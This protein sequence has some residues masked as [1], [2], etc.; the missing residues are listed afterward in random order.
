[1]FWKTINTLSEKQ[2]EN[3]N[4]PCKSIIEHFKRIY[5]SNPISDTI[6]NDINL[7]NDRLENELHASS[8]SHDLDMPFTRDEILLALKSLKLGKSASL[9]M[10]SNEMLKYS[11]NCILD[12]LLKLFNLVYDKNMFPKLW[13]V[14]ILVPIFKKGSKH[15]PNNYRGISIISC[16]GKL[17]NKIL[18]TRLQ[19]FCENNNLLSSLQIGFRPHSR[20]SDHIFALKSLIDIQKSKNQKLFTA[21]IDLKKAF[22]SVWHAGLFTK[23][24][25]T[26]IGSKMYWIIKS[27]YTDA[28]SRIK[29]NGGL[30]DPFK[31]TCG[32]KQGDVLSPLL[33]NLYINDIVNHMSGPSCDPVHINNTPIP[34]LMYADDIILVSQSAHGLQN[35]L[36]KLEEYCYQWRLTVNENKSNVVVF[37]SNG[38]SNQYTYTYNNTCLNVAK[39]YT[40]LGLQMMF[41][42]KFYAAINALSNKATKAYFKIKT[43]V[44]P[45]TNCKLQE[46]LFDTLISPISLYASEIWAC[47]IDFHDSSPFEK[48]HSKFLKYIQGVHFK[49]SNI[50][51][52]MGLQRLPLKSKILGNMIGFLQHII[53]EKGSIAHLI[54][55]NTQETNSWT[56]F[57]K[58]YLTS[59]GFAFVAQNLS[60][61]SEQI[62]SIKQRIN[63]I[64]TQDE[65]GQLYSSSKLELFQSIFNRER[66]PFMDKLNKID[67]RAVL[68]KLLFSAHELSIEKGRY[69]NIPRNERVC[70]SCNANKI[71]TER[72]FI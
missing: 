9:D 34:I 56:K 24:L 45:N 72:H 35:S 42:G 62:T 16:L 44:G 14:G 36:N 33:F 50:A 15:D 70:N 13:N 68:S 12:P 5:N 51:C 53:E 3:L 67:E 48:L 41:N 59:I 69:N 1:Q 19:T 23:L 6:H 66:L 22:D 61:L 32:V 26:G 65:V 20:T 55:M 40:Y 2:P 47:Q 43:T 11:T 7:E 27:M 25:R 38:K 30:T 28:H 60:L 46:K 21:C 58:Q 52:R 64:I 37:N 31:T 29:F 18:N 39:S 63:D 4:L 49:T 54:L 8:D 10:I 57:V 71:E 17:F